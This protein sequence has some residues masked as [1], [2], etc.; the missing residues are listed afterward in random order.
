MRRHQIWTPA[1]DKQLRT[2][3][4]ITGLSASTVNQRR[5]ALSDFFQKLN[6]SDGS[7]SR[8][9]R[10]L[11]R[12]SEEPAEGHRPPDGSRA[13]W[14]TW[15]PIGR[16]R[17]RLS[18]MHWTGMRPSQQG[19]LTGP[20]DFYL[21]DRAFIVD[22]NGQPR[23]VPAVMVPSGKGR[24]AR[25]VSVGPGRKK[26]SPGHFLRV[27]AF[28]RLP[29]P[30]A[31]RAQIA[32]LERKPQTSSRTKAIARLQT[33]LARKPRQTME[34]PDRLQADR[35]SRQGRVGEAPFTVYTIKHSFASGLRHGDRPRQTSRTC[36]ATRTSRARA[37]MRR[38]A[39][40]TRAGD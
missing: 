6:G 11:V 36:S 30:D 19:R 24:R 39:G 1:I 32:A 38:G 28:W 33:A 16:T 27:D 3:R 35:R 21:D 9:G 8:Q 25:D 17:W 13:C 40:E 29:T 22:I 18:L 31:L 14:R 15:I 10:R 5:D 26:R 23:R 12:A 2:W 34:L 7:R 37:S 4:N 20:D